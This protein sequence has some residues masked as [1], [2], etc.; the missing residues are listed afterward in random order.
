MVALGKQINSFN[1]PEG[2]FTNRIRQGVIDADY[3]DVMATI[4][5]RKYADNDLFLLRRL[6]I[7][8]SC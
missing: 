8:E 2:K 7:S 5:A 4:P 3:S 6:G 1:Y